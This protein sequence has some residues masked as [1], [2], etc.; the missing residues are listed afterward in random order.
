MSNKQ[1][2]AYGKI[3]SKLGTN[4]AEE[5]IYKFA[6][7][8]EMKRRDLNGVNCIKDDQ[9]VLTKEGEIKERFNEKPSSSLESLSLS[10][11]LSLMHAC[12]VFSF[13]F[14]I[15]HFF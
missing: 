7:T 1:C 8:M 15:S 10:L 13:F 5:N 2:R 12:L 4:D 11:S 6:K 9:R 3:Y 14:T